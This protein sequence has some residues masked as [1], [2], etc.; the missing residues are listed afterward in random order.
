MMW[1]ISVVDTSV[2]FPEPHTAGSLHWL[3]QI[4]KRLRLSTDIAALP[5]A[6]PFRYDQLRFPNEVSTSECVSAIPS[7]PGEPQI[8]RMVPASSGLACR[9]MQRATPQFL[10]SLEK[11]W[12]ECHSILRH[13]DVPDLPDPV[14]RTGTVARCSLAGVCLCSKGD[15]LGAFCSSFIAALR[16]LFLPKTLGRKALKDGNCVL[17][18]RSTKED[19]WWM[20]VAWVNLNDFHTCFRR[21][22]V[23]TDEEHIR[24]AAPSQVSGWALRVHTCGSFIFRGFV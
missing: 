17:R 1:Q 16:K 11:L 23:S 19:D 15:H 14:G 4:A 10:T 20:H 18:F 24:L 13:V 3:F 7:S 8:A 9:A 21:V 22:Y 5:V 12:A 2:K 6:E